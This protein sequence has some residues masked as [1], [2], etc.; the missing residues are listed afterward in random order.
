ME[1]Q[2]TFG[3]AGQL[4]MQ[5]LYAILILVVGWLVAKGVAWLV[6]KLLHWVRLDERIGKAGSGT[7]APHVEELVTKAVY[8]LILLFVVVATLQAP[9]LTMVTQPLNLMLGAIYAYVPRLILGGVVIFIA[10]LVAKILRAITRGFLEATKL[11]KP[12]PRCLRS[13]AWPFARIARPSIGWSGCCS[14]RSSWRHSGW[15][16]CWCRSWTC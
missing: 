14:S 3:S 5:V 2:P 10:W 8:Y 1:L 15:K 16:G 9:G 11:N 6:R 7:E 12:G 13:S 4:L